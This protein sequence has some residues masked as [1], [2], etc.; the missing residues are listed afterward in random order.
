MAAPP[1]YSVGLKSK[2]TIHSL[3]RVGMVVRR[4]SFTSLCSPG[5]VNTPEVGKATGIGF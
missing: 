4:E 1:R 5:R 3:A 2:E